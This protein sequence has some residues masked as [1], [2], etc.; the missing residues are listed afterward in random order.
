MTGPTET[1]RVGDA[2]CRLTASGFP[3]S[4]ANNFIFFFF[5]FHFSTFLFLSLPSFPFSFFFLLLSSS[6][7]L[8][9]LLCFLFFYLLIQFVAI[10]D[11][12]PEIP[13]G[14][15]AERREAWVVACDPTT[16][17]FL[18]LFFSRQN[19]P[20]IIVSSSSSLHHLPFRLLY[21]W[22]CCCD[23]CGCGCCVAPRLELCFS[24]ILVSWYLGNIGIWNTVT[25]LPLCAFFP[26]Q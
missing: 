20:L 24:G 6:S 18:L 9:S 15:R 8:L 5:D 16:P 3:V 1:R 23:C 26:A 21:L 25:R 19:Q 2:T 17:L 4:R 14:G 7:S 10:K 12:G 22:R 13:I 11:S